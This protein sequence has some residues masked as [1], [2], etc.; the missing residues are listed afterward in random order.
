MSASV[1][2]YPMEP[3]TND[4]SD[5][6]VLEVLGVRILVRQRKQGEG[7][8]DTYIN[9]QAPEGCVTEVNEGGENEYGKGGGK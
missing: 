2:W 1:D 8:T 7:R 4:A 5:T 6:Y 3:G 9:I